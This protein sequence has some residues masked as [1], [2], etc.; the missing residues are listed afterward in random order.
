MLRSREAAGRIPLSVWGV[1]IDEWP[2]DSPLRIAYRGEAWGIDMLRIFARARIVLNRHIDVAEDYANNMRLF[3]ATGM[4]ALLLTDDK[5]NLSELFRPGAEVI[6]YGD[7]DELVSQVEHYL[8]DRAT[9]E[10]MASAGQRRTLAEHSYAHRMREL[11]PLL[12]RYAA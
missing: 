10:L 5:R 1:G 9:A 11:V 6:T 3:E 4:G 7:A 8:D 2:R 12:E